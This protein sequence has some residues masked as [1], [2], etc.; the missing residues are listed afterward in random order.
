[1]DLVHLLIECGADVNAITAVPRWTPLH[2]LCENYK[3]DNLIEIVKLLIEKGA[4]VDEQSLVGV[5]PLYLVCQHFQSE[6]LVDIIQLLI[7]NGA[8]VNT[9]TGIRL[10]PLHVLCKNYP[11]DKVEWMNASIELLI[12]HR[13]DINAKADD[14]STPEAILIERGFVNRQLLDLKICLGLST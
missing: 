14:G 7:E 8:K 4:K 6:N 10:S 3:N 11:T 1:M 12:L 9:K 13:A 5:T 2:L